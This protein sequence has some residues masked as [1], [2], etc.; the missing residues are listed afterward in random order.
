MKIKGLRQVSPFVPGEQPQDQKL[1]KLN[2]NENPYPPSPKVKKAL[3]EF[4]VDQLKYYSPVEQDELRQAIADHLGVENDMIIIGS[5]SD[6]VLSMSFLAFFNNPQAILFPDLTYG[7]YKTLANLYGIPYHEIPLEDDFTLSNQGYLQENGG[8]VLVNPNAPTGLGKPLSEIKAI[9]KAN[10]QVMVIVD[11]AYINFGGQTA[12]PLLKDYPNLF[13]IRT[14]SKDA[15]LA[16]LRV[17]Y[18]IGHPQIIDLMKAI[19]DS[20]NPYNLDS[21]AEVLA[22]ATVEDWTYYEKTIAAIC[23]TRE[24]FKQELEKMDYTVIPSFT[25]FLL[26]KPQGIAASDLY[27]HLKDHHIYTRYFADAIRIKDYLRISIGSQSD[28]ET[29]VKVLQALKK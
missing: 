7:F 5:G 10:P 16:G 6:E 14:F 15:S 12:L 9:L 4:D 8:I 27:Q 17:G 21:I 25:N 11:E 20:V 18:G 1:I 22:K 2:T 28:M 3:K 19:K 26:V 23:Q 24:W 13:I 29:V